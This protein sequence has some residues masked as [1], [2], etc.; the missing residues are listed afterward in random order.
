M[1][2]VYYRQIKNAKIVVLYLGAIW[3]AVTLLV[4]RD[5]RHACFF[6][7]KYFQALK[8]LQNLKD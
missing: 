6:G 5:F 1:S 4:S 7:W 2:Y 3:V 8:F